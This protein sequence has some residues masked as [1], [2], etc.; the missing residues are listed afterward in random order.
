MEY[1]VVFSVVTH[2]DSAVDV[3]TSGKFLFN[4]TSGSGGYCGSGK[5]DSGST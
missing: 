2:D 5:A 4:F 3:S 1:E